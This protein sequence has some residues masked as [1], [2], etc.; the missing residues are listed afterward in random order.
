MGLPTQ[1]FGSA[2]E[3]QT[4]L[5]VRLQRTVSA[6]QVQPPIL[7]TIRD[8][9]PTIFLENLPDPVTHSER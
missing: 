1:C 8:A 2:A 6:R 5:A 9:G 7:R 4:V 3:L